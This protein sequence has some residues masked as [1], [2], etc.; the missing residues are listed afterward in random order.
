LYNGNKHIVCGAY[1]YIGGA[2]IHL[3]ITCGVHLVGAR[4][5]RDVLGAGIA[6]ALKAR[7][8]DAVEASVRDRIG[9]RVYDVVGA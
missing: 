3:Y 6:N 1:L 7:A 2:A 4:A 5:S 8:R 9:A